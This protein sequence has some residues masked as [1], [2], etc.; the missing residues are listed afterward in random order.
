VAQDVIITGEDCGTLRGLSETA[1]KNNEEV[2][3]TLY[4]RI[5][6][7]VSCHDIY[8]PLTG[9]L[10]VHAGEEIKEDVANN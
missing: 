6:G 2:V 8:H 9:E 5:L 4:D 7:R 3:E 1:L 10:V